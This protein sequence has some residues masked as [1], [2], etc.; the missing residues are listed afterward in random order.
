[1]KCIYRFK[2]AFGDTS[3]T[4]YVAVSFS[5][6]DFSFVPCPVHS[7]DPILL[8]WVFYKTQLQHPESSI[9][10]LYPTRPVQEDKLSGRQMLFSSQLFSFSPWNCAGLGCPCRL[11]WIFPAELCF[12][13]PLSE[14]CKYVVRK[15]FQFIPFTFNLSQSSQQMWKVATNFE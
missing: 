14:N 5:K 15:A 7:W 12:V 13:R 9:L 8:T 1:M 2:L 6:E 4:S 11:V 3:V 10:R